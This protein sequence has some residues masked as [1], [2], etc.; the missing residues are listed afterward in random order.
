[1]VRHT[2][3]LHIE[4]ATKYDLLGEE[5]GVVTK[6]NLD[7]MVKKKEERKKRIVQEKVE[8][9]EVK[10]D[11]S[12]DLIKKNIITHLGVKL[13]IN[14]LKERIRRNLTRATNQNLV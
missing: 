8:I 10:K 12:V 14:L 5:S 13:S 6:E 11:K 2:K 3:P 4:N 9:G 7:L 1:M